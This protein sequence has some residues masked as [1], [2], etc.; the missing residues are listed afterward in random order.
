MI[1]PQT[2]M[3]KNFLKNLWNPQNNHYK[4]HFFLYIAVL[5]VVF[6]LF[7][8]MGFDLESQK[9]SMMK[10]LYFL[11]A[12]VVAELITTFIITLIDLRKS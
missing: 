2:A 8:S 10:L 9:S 3:F 6:M 4:L 5:F 7:D 1:N 12:N 11:I